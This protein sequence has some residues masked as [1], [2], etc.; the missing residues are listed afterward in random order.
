VQACVQCGLSIG[1]LATFCPVC[2]TPVGDG[3]AVAI[4]AEAGAP[5]ASGLEPELDESLEPDARESEPAMQPEPEQA[6]APVTELESDSRH[7]S[8]ANAEFAHLDAAPVIGHGAI[9]DADPEAGSAELVSELVG[10]HKA[11]T[12]AELEAPEAEEPADAEEPE[13]AKVEESPE[14][15][16]E[17]RIAE[18]AALLE[19]AGR[20]EDVNAAR[21]AAVYG[22]AIVGCLGVTDD[23]L[24]V[25]PVRTELLHGFDRLSFVLERQGLP[26]EALAVVDDAASLGLLD[27]ENGAAA[28]QRGV[29]RDRRE[30][31]RHVLYGDSAQL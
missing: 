13:P 10:G 25:E 15:A 30:G 28:P 26:E 31:L 16:R 19:F 20:C 29:L 7:A 1:D 24:S 21:A 18:I 27:G 4:A 8:D 14:Q 12:G 17:R 3:V 9:L 6:A 23:P 2:G 22:E 5:L 11:Q